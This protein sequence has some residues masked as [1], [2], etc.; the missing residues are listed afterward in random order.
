M[1]RGLIAATGVA[2]M[3]VS[4]A[5]CGS[6]DSDKETG[7]DGSRGKT[8]TVWF[9][10]GSNPPAWTKAVQAE[11]EQKTGAKL[12]IQIQKWD[13][14][15]QKLTTA[16]SESSPPDV[17]EIGNTQTPSYAQTGG[18]AE[19]DDLKKE[20][21]ADWTDSLNKPAVFEGKQYAAPWYAASRV[22]IYNKKIWADAGIKDTPKTREEFFKDLDAIQKK[23]DAE[24][25]YLPGQNWYFFDGLTIGTG[26][27]LVKKDGKK[28][29]SNLGDPKVAKAMDV[30]KQYQSFSKAPKD[31]DE[32]TPQQADVFAKGKT[33]AFIGMGWEA[34]T[35]IK[36]NPEIEKEIGYFTIPGESA[37]KPEGVFLGGS[38][39]A[40]SEGSKKKELAKEFLKIA[41]SDKN[42]GALSKEVGSIPNK[43][44]LLA[45]VKGNAAAE[46]AAPAAK[47]GGTTPLIPEW[48]AVENAPNPVKAYMTAV[49]SGKSPEEAAKQVEADMNK[50]LS[51]KQ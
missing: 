1:K 17:V 19:L 48:A 18:L 26:A 14:I 10:D 43:E 6:S 50:R 46:A 51:Q 39:L 5:A 36:A 32:A 40:I 3:L 42:E 12:D 23:G 16:L 9:M 27:D 29:V 41:L 37:D 2:A 4:V 13:G 21:G 11:F 7:A 31:K 15:Q 30:Y 45:N 49:L 25:L 8:L 35:A 34:Q 24:P 20:I 33:G 38:N 28:Y 22:V 44:A 47:G